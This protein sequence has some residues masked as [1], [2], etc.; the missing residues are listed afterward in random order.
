[1][2][3]PANQPCGIPDNCRSSRNVG[4]YHSTCS[5]EGVCA[6]TLPLPHHRTRTN[7]RALADINIAGYRR[8]RHYGSKIPNYTVVTDSRASPYV[9]VFT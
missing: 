7:C 4:N 3:L 9:H 8:E 2:E 1:M 6:D 5:N